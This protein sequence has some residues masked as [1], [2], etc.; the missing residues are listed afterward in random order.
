ML[1]AGAASAA[2]CFRAGRKGDP[3]SGFSALGLGDFRLRASG[4]HSRVPG[5]TVALLGRTSFLP[6]VTSHTPVN[7]G[8]TN[9]ASTLLMEIELVDEAELRGYFPR[10]Q[11]PGL[12][13]FQLYSRARRAEGEANYKVFIQPWSPE[14]TVSGP[15]FRIADFGANA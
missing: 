13:I 10:L 15:E 7:S 3:R 8:L 1:S 6:S 2:G 4:T 12:C 14:D 11:G 9:Q 5:S